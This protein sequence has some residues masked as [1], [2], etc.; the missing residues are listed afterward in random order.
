MNAHRMSRERANVAAE[1]L[2]GAH[3]MEPFPNALGISNRSH[4]IIGRQFF[5]PF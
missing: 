1:L 2:R 3:A 4:T 5:T